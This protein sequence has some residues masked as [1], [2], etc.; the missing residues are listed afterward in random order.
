[1]PDTNS[2][3]LVIDDD[4]D[5][6]ASVG[7]LLRSVGV[8]VQLFASISEFLESDPTDGPT[9]AGRDGVEIILGRRFR[10]SRVTLDREYL[11]WVLAV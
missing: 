11:L 9:I 3:V 4:P 2:I 7:R 6:R 8:D 1:M 10:L 5:V